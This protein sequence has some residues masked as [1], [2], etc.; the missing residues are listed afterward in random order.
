[1]QIFLLL[2]LPGC[3]CQSLELWENV[4]KASSVPSASFQR[5]SENHRLSR[6]KKAVVCL[7][8]Q[9]PYNLLVSF[10]EEGVGVD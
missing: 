4:T 7:S 10:M 6:F 3:V 5:E 2:G 8:N 9:I 1:M